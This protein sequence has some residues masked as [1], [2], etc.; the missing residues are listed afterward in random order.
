MEKTR[1]FKDWFTSKVVLKMFEESSIDFI[2]NLLA[3]SFQKIDKI[4]VDKLDEI[5]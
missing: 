4:K 1:N 3:E 2:E 5:K